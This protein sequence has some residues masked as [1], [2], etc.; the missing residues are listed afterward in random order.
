MKMKL[1]MFR[2]Q[3]ETKDLIISITKNCETLT[4]QTQTKSHETFE[5]QLTEP[6]Q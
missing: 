2:L 1:D 5:F 3:N 6:Q 4:K